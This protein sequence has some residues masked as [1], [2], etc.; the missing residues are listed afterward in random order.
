MYI[1]SVADPTVI[2]SVMAIILVLPYIPKT[3]IADLCVVEK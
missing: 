3:V 1:I 2:E